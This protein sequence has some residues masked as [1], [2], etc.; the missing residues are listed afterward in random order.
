MDKEYKIEDRLSLRNIDTG[1]S[2]CVPLVQ[3]PVTQHLV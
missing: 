1:Y 2:Y 3:L